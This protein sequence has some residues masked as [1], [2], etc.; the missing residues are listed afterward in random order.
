MCGVGMTGCSAMRCDSINGLPTSVDDGRCAR[1]LDDSLNVSERKTRSG[2]WV[3]RHSAS[4]TLL[5]EWSSSRFPNDNWHGTNS[6]HLCH[7]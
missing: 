5:R 7:N 2:R 1:L 4:F 3:T 6:M